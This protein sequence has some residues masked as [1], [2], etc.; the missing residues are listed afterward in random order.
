LT[1]TD[2]RRVSAKEQQQSLQ[3]LLDKV[4]HDMRLFHSTVENITLAF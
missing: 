4:L 1:E 3:P 2:A